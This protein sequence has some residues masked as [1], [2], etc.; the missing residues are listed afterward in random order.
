MNPSSQNQFN[1]KVLKKAISSSIKKE[2]A[3]GGINTSTRRGNKEL[4]FLTGKIARYPFNSLEQAQMAGTKLGQH[5]ADISQKRGKNNLDADIIGQISYQSDLL[6]IVGLPAV[7]TQ[8]DNQEV[9]AAS[10]PPEPSTSSTTPTEDTTSIDQEQLTEEIQSS[11]ESTSNNSPLP[12]V[13][14]TSE[15]S[16]DVTALS[17]SIGEDETETTA[18]TSDSAELD[19]QESTSES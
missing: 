17:E 2:I 18:S 8:P 10:A 11:D 7:P 4:K 6:S 1:S 16:N 19:T 9:Q 15:P 13:E 14:S 12:E 3:A 5:I